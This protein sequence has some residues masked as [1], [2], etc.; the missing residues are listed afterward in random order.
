MTT[1][2]TMIRIPT[3]SNKKLEDEAKRRGQTKNGLINYII[4]VYLEEQVKK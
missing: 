2:R 1:K 4:S 3:E